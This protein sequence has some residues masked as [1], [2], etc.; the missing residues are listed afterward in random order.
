MTSSVTDKT[1]IP[2]NERRRHTD[3]PSLWI[4]IA[5]SSVSLHLLVFWFMR[6]SNVFKP[7]FPEQNQTIVPIEFIE[8]SPT[9][10]S[11][12]KSNLEAEIVS[13]KSSISAQESASAPLPETSVAPITPSYQDTE[14]INSDASL[15]R[16]SESTIEASPPETPVLP[17]ETVSTPVP[18]PVPTPT[19][20]IPVGDLPWNRRQEVVL[21]QGQA[22]P[23]DI[24]SISSELPK[25]SEAEQAETARILEEEALP[26]PT[27]ETANT[28]EEEALPTPTGET[29][30]TPEEEALP[31]PTGATANTPEEEALPTPTGETANTPEEEALPTPTG[32][33][34]NTPT[35]TGVRVTFT[36]VNKTEVDQLIL[37]GRIRP[38]GLPDVL[39][40]HKGNNTKNLELSYIPGDSAIEPVQLLASLVIDQNGNFQQAQ[41][42]EIEPAR[43]Q[44]KRSLYEQVVNNFFINDRFLPAQNNDGTRPEL[45]NLFIRITIQPVN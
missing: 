16:E 18:T 8:I 38:D 13:P 12:D 21:G 40:V 32:A 23:S 30:N 6:S 9:A 27:G 4:A 37:E 43:L 33:T 19:P 22:L 5:I 31:T 35:E 14:T 17:E 44:D 11:P 28:P 36:P 26:T 15:F 24:P 2:A 3:P 1:P 39:A 10:E 25:L 34:A 42:L 41:V 7:W 45:S 20:T 29:A